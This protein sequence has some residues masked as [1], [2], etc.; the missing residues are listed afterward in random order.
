PLCTR[1]FSFLILLRPPMST[2]FPYTTLV[3]SQAVT[4]NVFRNDHFLNAYNIFLEADSHE[5]GLTLEQMG[6][7]KAKMTHLIKSYLSKE[8]LDRKSTRLNSS[9]VKSSYA[10]F[11]LKKK[12]CSF[13][14]CAR[15]GWRR[16]CTAC[17][18]PGVG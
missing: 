12:R 11:C 7:S 8:A 16:S 3:R 17:A 18:A 15:R 1:A 14:L 13:F 4:H 6:Y 10:V 2:L 5:N 9:H